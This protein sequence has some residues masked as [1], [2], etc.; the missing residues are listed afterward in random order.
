MKLYQNV[1]TI[2]IGGCSRSGKTVLTRELKNTYKSIIDKN[3]EFTDIFGS[4][5]LDR[6]FNKSKIY[7]N[8]IRTNLGNGYGNWEFP[9]AL[10]W[11]DFYAD[12][13]K[14]LKEINDKIRNSSTPNKKGILFIEGFLLYSPLMADKNDEFNYL[15]LFDYYIYICLNKSIAKERRM[16]T[17]TVPDDYYEC[18]LWPEHLKYCSKYIDFFKNRSNKNNILIIDGNKKYN[19]NTVALCILKWI[20]AYKQSN[21]SINDFYNT[22][23]TSFDKQINILENNFK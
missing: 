10:D 12:I 16:K 15:N 22:L 3:S 6:Y 13:N 5:H 20:G 8:Y 18:I 2:G 23:F 11:D 21:N 1:I 17:T 9:G 14:K 4:V 19:P 7:K